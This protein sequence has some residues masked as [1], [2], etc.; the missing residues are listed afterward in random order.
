IPGDPEDPRIGSR[1]CGGRYE[2]RRRVA[3]GGMGR[4]YQARDVEAHR[5]V[6]LK[7]LHPEVAGDEVAVER[8]RREY[9]LS[10]ELPHAHIVEVLDFQETGDGTYALVMEYLEGEELRM[11]LKRQKTV[12]P[13]RLVRMLSQL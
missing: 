5:S 11:L 13:A 6:A 1:A 3:D 12:A 2:I 8:F 9:R 10:A 4:V 7:I